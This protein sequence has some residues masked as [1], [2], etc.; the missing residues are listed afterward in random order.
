MKK[1][2]LSIML[3]LTL[4]F[5]V[6]MPVMATTGET[7]DESKK[8]ATV[9]DN[10]QSDSYKTSAPEPIPSTDANHNLTLTYK[11]AELKTVAKNTGI[12]RDIDAAWIG[13]ELTTPEGATKYE[14]T[15]K[16]EKSTGEITDSKVVDFVAVTADKLKAATQ[17]N[18][19][20][21][22]S[23]TYKWLKDAAKTVSTG[24]ENETGATEE[25]STQTL[26]IV[27]EPKGVILYDGVTEGAENTQLWNETLYTANLPKATTPS[28]TNKKTSNT[29]DDTPTMGTVNVYVIAGLVAVLT[30]AGA[31]VLNKRK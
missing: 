29:K 13:Y 2:L 30:L 21:V 26:N 3:V 22:Y 4:V 16:G 8:Y 9:K 24:D 5:A 11:A 18:E 27:I 31:V 1:N 14:T 7:T 28:T 19:K 15:Y 23:I 6:T 20:L 12:H 10:T 17:N 25:I